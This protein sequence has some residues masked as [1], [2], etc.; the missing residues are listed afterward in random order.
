MMSSREPDPVCDTLDGDGCLY[1]RCSGVCID[2]CLQLD[3]GDV[4]GVASR[5][6]REE[7]LKERKLQTGTEGREC[8]ETI[9]VCPLFKYLKERTNEIFNG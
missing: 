3:R 9:R 5:N 4:R 6:V 8:N 2:H 7:M 1:S